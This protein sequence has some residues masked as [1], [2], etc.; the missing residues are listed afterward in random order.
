MN[1]GIAQFRADKQFAVDGGKL[2]DAQLYPQLAWCGRWV[3]LSSK[4]ADDGSDW[5]QRN[6]HIDVVLQMN[7]HTS[8]TV[9]EKIV[10]RVYP[11]FAIELKANHRTPGQDGWFY[12]TTA[13]VLVF[14]FTR[15]DGGIEAH[16]MAMGALRGYLLPRMGQYPLKA[17]DN[18]IYTSTVLLLPVREC[19]K[20]DRAYLLQPGPVTVG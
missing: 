1:A 16:T 5:L 8:I 10:R 2:L 6:A 17:V 18:G 4:I 19:K 12:A 11:A 14:A 7:E 13:D 20:F 3:R 15:P 9:E